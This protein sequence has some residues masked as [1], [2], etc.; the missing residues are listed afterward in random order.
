[1]AESRELPDFLVIG[2]M[3]GGTT[4]LY[5]YLN[6]H[7]EIFMTKVKEVDF[8]TQELNWDKGFDWYT[9]QF[10]DAGPDV[11]K[12]EASTSYTKFPRYSGVAPR[13]AEHLPKARLIYVVRDPVERIRSHY[14]HNVAIGEE[15]LEIE[16]AVE[17]NPVYL[18]YSR[19]AMQLDQYLE[20]FDEDRILVITSEGLR[21]DREATFK[22][23]LRFLEV[24]AEARVEALEREYY[25]TEERPAYGPIVGGV[26]RTLKR[27]FPKNVA[28]WRGQ[29]LPASVKRRLSRQ[30]AEE[31]RSASSTVPERVRSTVA[32]ELGP[33]IERLRAHLGRDFD[34]WGIA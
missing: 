33:D 4:S 20:H 13:I 21:D 27:L 15:P 3:K 1:V 8:F 31:S 25:K 24:D 6:A 18:D 19:Y 9:K 32:R 34:G 29:F 30:S 23:V 5:H 26:R 17:E 14:Q 16:R 7:P 22:K 28:L 11:K 10:A 12:G 2:A